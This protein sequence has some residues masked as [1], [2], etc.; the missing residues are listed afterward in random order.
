MIRSHDKRPCTLSRTLA[1]QEGNEGSNVGKIT[2]TLF[3]YE[4]LGSG[5]TIS[6]KITPKQASKLSHRNRIEVR[7]HTRGYH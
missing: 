3:S 4:P 1:I 2:L 7:C 5:N 6:K